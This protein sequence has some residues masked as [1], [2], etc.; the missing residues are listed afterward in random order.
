MDSL[1]ILGMAQRIQTAMCTSSTR[2][3]TG[4]KNSITQATLS[5]N[6]ECL[7][8][9]V[10]ACT[11]YVFQKGL[12]LILVIMC[13]SVIVEMAELLNILHLVCI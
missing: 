3:I 8:A 2:E 13:M 4:F 6:G 10:L 5:R 1:I 12:P 11:I 9:T 7:N